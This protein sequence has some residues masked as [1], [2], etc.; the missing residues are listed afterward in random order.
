[1]NTGLTIRHSEGNLLILIYILLK[2]IFFFSQF[3]LISTPSR[4]FHASQSLHSSRIFM[5]RSLA[6][7]LL[8]ILFIKAKIAP[9]EAKQVI[10]SCHR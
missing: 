9:G 3:H 8:F 5:L 10:Q 4:S 1:M 6:L 7:D 2:I